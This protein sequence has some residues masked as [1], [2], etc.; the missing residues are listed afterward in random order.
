VIARMSGGV[1]CNRCVIYVL[2]AE[3]LAL[4]QVWV[5]GL[6]CLSGYA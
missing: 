3:L 2:G 6:D 5:W 1:A 4:H